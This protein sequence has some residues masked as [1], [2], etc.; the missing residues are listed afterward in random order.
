M[1]WPVCIIIPQRVNH[2]TYPKSYVTLSQWFT[3]NFV[4]VKIGGVLLPA[5]SIYY[6]QKKYSLKLL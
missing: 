3:G 4:A 6:K 1:H 5:F 2:V